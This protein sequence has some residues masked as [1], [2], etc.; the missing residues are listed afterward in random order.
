MATK[1]VVGDPYDPNT[2]QGPQIDD[3]QFDKIMSL[4]NT[5]RK[6]GA[7]LQTGGQR[8]GSKGF[9]IQPTV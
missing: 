9:F 5:G 2:Q 6:E 3:T 7:R 8:A 4:I 1:R